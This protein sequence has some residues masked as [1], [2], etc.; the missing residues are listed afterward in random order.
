MGVSRSSTGQAIKL[1]AAADAIVGKHAIQS[2]RLEHSAAAN[3]VLTETAGATIAALRIGAAGA[4][5]ISFSPPVI[6]DGVIAATLSAGT[7]YVY[8]A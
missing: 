7:V 1:G 4:D 2:I 8:L 3:A 5:T 6:V